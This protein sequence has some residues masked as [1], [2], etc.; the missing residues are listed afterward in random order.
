[1]TNQL[2]TMT[3]ILSHKVIHLKTNEGIVGRNYLI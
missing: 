2:K 3:L 1:M